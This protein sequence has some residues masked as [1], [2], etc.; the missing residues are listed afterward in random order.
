MSIEQI[1]FEK[2]TP[3]RIA[4]NT[5]T[6]TKIKFNPPIG[7]KIMFVRVKETC[8]KFEGRFGNKN[9]FCLAVCRENICIYNLSS[10]Y[11]AH[12]RRHLELKIIFESNRRMQTRHPIKVCLTARTFHSDIF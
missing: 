11:V 12:G 6:N 3:L 9:L 5:M 10:R 8:K 2:S 1:Y 4:R 7:A